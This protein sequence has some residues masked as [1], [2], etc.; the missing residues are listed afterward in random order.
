MGWLGEKATSFF[1]LCSYFIE[2]FN[3]LSYF[4]LYEFHLLN[5]HSSVFQNVEI[6]GGTKPLSSAQ[7]LFSE[8]KLLNRSTNFGQN[9]QDVA[10]ILK[11][12]YSLQSVLF[13]RISFI[14]YL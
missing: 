7:L 8:K 9:F 6:L 5:I 13:G 12:R 4:L 14:N 2:S 3:A 1:V 11:V 10:F